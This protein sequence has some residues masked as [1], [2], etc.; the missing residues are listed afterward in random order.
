[1]QQNDRLSALSRAQA[2]PVL[3]AAASIWAL[4]FGVGMLM[5]G[6]GLQNTLLGVRANDENFGSSVTGLV[7]SGFFAGFLLGSWLSPRVIQRVGHL[8]LFAAA[9]S[10]ASI[11]ILLQSI[12]VHPIGWALMRVLAG[13][14]QATALIVSESW[15]NARITNEH[16]GKLLSIYNIITY[17]GVGGG[18]LLLNLADPGDTTLFILVSVL[19]SFAAVPILLSMTPQPLQDAPELLSLRELYRASPLGLIGSS[20]AGLLQGAVFGMGAVYAQEVGM[21][22]GQ[23]SLF[24]FVLIGGVALF[25]WPVGMLSDRIDRRRVITGLALVG[26]AV[27]L[28]GIPASASIN[29]LML[30]APLMG[31]GPMILYSLFVAHTND[32]LRPSQMVAASSALVL[33]FGVGASFGPSLTGILM[34]LLG[35]SGWLWVLALGQLGIG[36]FTL[37]RMTRREAL[38]VAEQSVYVPD[39][40]QTAGL[41]PA[42]TQQAVDHPATNYSEDGAADSQSH[43]EL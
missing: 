14:C 8:R 33:V 10:L 1:M 21:S 40:A 11:A 23:I 37:Y 3:S 39:A 6:S 13:Y 9:V 15:L 22:L 43:Q 20:M 4:L 32:Y 16:R 30:L 28:L 17:L 29:S 7:M 5:L 26:A 36:A 42:Q 18:Q 41:V 35:P 12:W 38:P 31:T 25:Q 27:A 19:L 2:R 24:M 34:D